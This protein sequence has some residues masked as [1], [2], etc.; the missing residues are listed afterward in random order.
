MKRKEKRKEEKKEEGG[1]RRIYWP[2]V[3]MAYLLV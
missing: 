2:C 1:G 3:L